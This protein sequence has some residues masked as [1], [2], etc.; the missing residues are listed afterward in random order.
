MAL[1]QVQTHGI[2]GAGAGPFLLMDRSA[3]N[4]VPKLRVIPM[5][6]TEEWKWPL[7]PVTDRATETKMSNMKTREWDWATD[8]KEMQKA[9]KLNP[10]SAQ[11]H[12]FY[13]DKLRRRGR[14]AESIGEGKRSIALD[15]LSPFHP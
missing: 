3:A 6:A 11:A 8:E 15:P 9:L 12:A 1:A 5:V 2:S 13:T 14:A 10:N 7:A 4:L